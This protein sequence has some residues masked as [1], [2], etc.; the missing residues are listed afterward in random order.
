MKLI[1]R[2]AVFLAAL[3]VSAAGTP[4]HA[5]PF[6]AP[7]L[8]IVD[9]GFF[10]V[11]VEVQAGP[12][13]APSGFTIDWMTRADFNIYGWPSPFQ[14]P[15]YSEICTFSGAPT[16][17]TEAGSTFGLGPNETVQI[18]LGDLFDE[19]DVAATWADGLPTNTELVLRV[20]AE[21]DGTS[22]RSAWS[23]NLSVSTTDG[24]CTQGFWK[25]HFELWPIGCTPM[26]L[27][28]V[29][30]TAAELL[31]I[32]NTPANGNGLI[33]MAHQLITTKLNYCNGSNTAAV[34]ATIATCDALI[35]G[36]VVPTVGA[37][38]L[39]PGATSAYTETL[40]DFNNGLILGAANCP[41]PVQSVTWGHVKSIYR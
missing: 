21:G 4:A 37:G 9:R 22:T 35:G 23:P 1:T 3:T 20:R 30:Y 6:D 15:L 27:G 12:S 28:T 41:T 14:P 40:D 24:S 26:T 16:L 8:S 39:A 29:S 38:Y 32:Y 2:A 25:T 5:V 13:G 34:A 36:L 17:N 7:T 33:A 10:R 11:T 18:Q 31:A 19:T